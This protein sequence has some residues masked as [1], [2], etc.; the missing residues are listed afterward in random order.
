MARDLPLVRQQRAAV[1]RPLRHSDLALLDA[2]IRR[3]VRWR[4]EDPDEHDVH[5]MPWPER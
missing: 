1:Q 2:A 5:V 3:V 4:E